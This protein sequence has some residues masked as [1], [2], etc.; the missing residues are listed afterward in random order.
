MNINI[1]DKYKNV[2]DIILSIT[3][4]AYLVGGYIRD[5]L[6]GIDN[7]DADIDIAVNG[8]YINKIKEELEKDKYTINIDGLKFGVITAYLEDGDNIDI[9]EFRNENYD[10]SSRKPKVKASDN[11]YDDVK[12]R[13]FT[14]NAIAYNLKR[15]ELIDEFNGQEDI[16]NKIIRAVGNPDERFDEDPLRILRGLRIATKLGFNIEEKTLKSMEKNSYKLQKV[17]G[18][19]IR[20]EL[21]KGL[22]INPKRFF[23]LLEESKVLYTLINEMEGAKEL[24]HG[25]KHG[26]YGENLIQHIIDVL[27]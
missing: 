18:E 15:K 23:E 17:S 24:K 20:D 1:P 21:I 22:E 2:I 8:K 13:D 4:E 25:N 16:K 7:K 11:I 26:H 5:A 9:A 3:P 6:I 12:R 14:I 19:R 27:D 10:S